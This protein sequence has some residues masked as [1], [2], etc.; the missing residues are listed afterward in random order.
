M[1]IS[2]EGG[3]FVGGKVTKKVMTQVNKTE[4]RC[5]YEYAD[6][7]DMGVYSPW[8]DAE[9][10]ECYIGFSVADVKVKKMG[11]KWLEDIVEKGEK[12]KKITG[13]EAELVG[14]QDVT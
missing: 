4:D 12:Y 1:G 5:L 10:A 6:K 11:N 9:Y 14:M 7:H 13:V 8:Y 2:T 3:M